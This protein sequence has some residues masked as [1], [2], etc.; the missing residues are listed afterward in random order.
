MRNT[1]ISPPPLCPYRLPIMHWDAGTGPFVCTFDTE[2]ISIRPLVLSVQRPP[3]LWDSV[4]NRGEMF[5]FSEHSLDFMKP[6]Q[7]DGD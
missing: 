5:R 1:I 6:R 3:L 4:Q 7:R 2:L